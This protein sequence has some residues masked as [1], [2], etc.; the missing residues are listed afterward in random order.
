MKRSKTTALL[1]MSAA[2]LL[3]TACGREP[4]AKAQEGLYTSVDACV[5]QTHDIAT[6]R[7]AFAQAQKQAAEQGPKYASREQCAQDYAQDRCV[8]QRD[9]HGHSF[10][11]PM[12]TGFFLS[13]MLNNNRAAG[14]N[15]APAY[16]DRQNQWQR[17]ASYSGG[18]GAT[19]ASGTM[20]RGNQTMTHIGATPNRA[21]T[22]SRGG[23]GESAGGRGFGS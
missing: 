4:E 8:E 21:V 5:A 6:C 23:F 14:F 22:V 3:F 20:L 13:Q 15:A 19:A 2:P 17:P 18:A 11:G 7:E 9:S 12:M 10:I 1:L 16:Q